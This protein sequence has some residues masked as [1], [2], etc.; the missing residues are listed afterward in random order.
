MKLNIIIKYIKGFKKKNI[1]LI[2]IM[3]CVMSFFLIGFRT[4]TIIAQSIENRE[5]E[6]VKN[7]FSG[8]LE[9]LT[10]NEAESISL[11]YNKSEFGSTYYVGD[12]NDE[13]YSVSL[14]HFDET[15]FHEFLENQLLDIS[16]EKPITSNEIMVSDQLATRYNVGIGDELFLK[17]KYKDKN[18]SN[19]FIVTGIMKY[20]DEPDKDICIVSKQFIDTLEDY[21]NQQYVTV[22]IKLGKFFLPTKFEKII[23]ENGLGEDQYTIN[24]AYN[25]YNT[26]KGI[27]LILVLVLTFI[28]VGYIVIKNMFS[29]I[30]D[31]QLSLL[32]QFHALGATKQQIRKMVYMHYGCIV[33]CATPLS[34]IVSNILARELVEK[35]DTLIN[36]QLENKGLNIHEVMLSIFCG[37]FISALCAYKPIK[38]LNKK[39][40][41]IN[42]KVR[43]KINKK[44]TINKLALINVSVGRGKNVTL[45]SALAVFV[46]LVVIFGT[47]GNSFSKEKY[48]KSFIKTDFVVA[49]KAYFHNKYNK[50][51]VL[52]LNITKE[53]E[54][55]KEIQGGRIYCTRT[56]GR[57]YQD[58]DTFK[59]L[60][61]DIFTTKYCGKEID[62]Q[63]YGMDDFPLSKYEVIDGTID[64]EKLHN[65]EGVLE[66]CDVDDFGNPILEST[67]FKVGDK[68]NIGYNNKNE[69][70][71]T[72]IGHVKN[73]FL[74]TDLYG[75]LDFETNIIM[76]SKEYCSS[77]DNP[78]LMNFVFDVDPDMYSDMEMYL[79]DCM[80]DK[81]SIDF[82][83]KKSYEDEYANLKNIFIIPGTI[84][85]GV[86]GIIGITNF[87]SSIYNKLLNRNKEFLT[88]R[89]IGMTYK[90]LWKLGI[91]EIYFYICMSMVMSTLIIGV[92]YSL[93][94]VNIE[95]Y[96]WF[97]KCG[98]LPSLSYIICYF[99]Y[100]ICA[101]LIV[102]K[103]LRRFKNIG[104]VKYNNQ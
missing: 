98:K 101:L 15:Y 21:K 60:D 67:K 35:L 90:Q 77:V 49:N 70:E 71:Y 87:C 97:C 66:I 92:I 94:I 29:L 42:D 73:I 68:I 52:D 51:N 65:G 3:I 69:K 44:L 93:L 39:E 74:F 32:K 78:L 6:K 14:F 50:N 8:S 84:F 17:Y 46:I 47:I 57:E 100:G 55:N 13:K 2:A 24:P 26:G 95:K 43:N 80:T 27:I 23:K 96:I 63:T 82:K 12:V 56:G 59:R 7:K 91:V 45:I 48:V 58:N 79:H 72:V 64:Y 99:V 28:L 30:L 62:L 53:L 31:E 85:W 61:N 41:D 9:G 40:K 54:A 88:Y 76:S 83:S 33:I 1:A 103:V 22:Y 86:I 38:M 20:K 25:Q 37:W 81:A 4:Y 36:L 34:I 19:K 16:G 104:D 102:T 18:I 75:T 11:S 10:A 89:Q 5:I